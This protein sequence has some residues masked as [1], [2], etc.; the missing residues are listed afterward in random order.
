MNFHTFNENPPGE[1]ANTNSSSNNSEAEMDR[2]PGTTG[3][4]EGKQEKPILERIRA[5]LQDWSNKDEADQ[6]YDDTRV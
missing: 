6:E 1:H 4:N 5:A 3:S 2:P